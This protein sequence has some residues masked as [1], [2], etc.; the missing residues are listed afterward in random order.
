MLELDKNIIQSFELFKHVFPEVVCFSDSVYF[1]YVRFS[2][3]VDALL[4]LKS[5]NEDVVSLHVHCYE[6]NDVFVEFA[7]W[8]FWIFSVKG[9]SV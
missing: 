1:L 8:F 2:P 9:E 5:A 6:P 7:K 3:T 4:E